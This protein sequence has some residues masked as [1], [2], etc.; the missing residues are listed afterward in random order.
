MPY[1]IIKELDGTYKV[2]N[3]DTKRILAKH[4]TKD[5]AEKQIKLLHTVENKKQN[6]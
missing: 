2:M 5:K 6:R 1:V 3:A 4:T